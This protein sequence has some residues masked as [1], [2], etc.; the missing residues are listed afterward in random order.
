MKITIVL[1]ARSIKRTI[2]LLTNI[3]KELVNVRSETLQ[4]GISSDNGQ[5]QVRIER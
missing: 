5:Y 2:E 3:I 4:F 1:E